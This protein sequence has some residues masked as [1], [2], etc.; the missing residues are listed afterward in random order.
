MDRYNCC[1][2]GASLGLDRPL[3]DWPRPYMGGYKTEG[4]SPNRRIVGHLCEGCMSGR[5]AP[6]SGVIHDQTRPT[7]P[8]NDR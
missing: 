1:E 6:K 3:A 2:C 8:D 5:K 4:Q 7:T